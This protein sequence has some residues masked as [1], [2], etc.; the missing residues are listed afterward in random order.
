MLE[1]IYQ[2]LM[3]TQYDEK[4]YYA[5]KLISLSNRNMNDPFKAL[6]R[7]TNREWSHKIGSKTS[8]TREFVFFLSIAQSATIDR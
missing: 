1:S 8:I 7:A 3:H 5:L 6:G 4:I 2:M